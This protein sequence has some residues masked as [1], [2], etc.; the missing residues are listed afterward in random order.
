MSAILNAMKSLSL[1]T[2]RAIFVVGIPGAGKTFFAE[3]FAETFNAPY[4]D[5]EKI[6]RTVFS[7]PTYDKNEQQAID[8]LALSYLTELL[9]TKKTLLFEGG[10][11]ARVD[12]MNLSK[13]V[14]THGYEPLFV[15]VQTEPA[16]ANSRATRGVRGQDASKVISQERYESLAAKFTPLN[17]TEDFVVISGKHTYATQARA[18]LKRLAEPRIEAEKEVPVRSVRQASRPGSIK[19]F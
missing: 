19:I 6:R 3:K 13:L 8:E 18:V 10:T 2:P 15:W 4:I 9:K 7:S 14:K 17:R 11:E 12:R 16:T 5:V 1:T